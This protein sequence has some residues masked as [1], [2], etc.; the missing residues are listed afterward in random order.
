L[1]NIIKARKGKRILQEV[2][3]FYK[4]INMKK[5]LFA[6]TLLTTAT[7]SF[8]NPISIP[9][10]ISDTPVIIG[11]N[12]SS[13]NNNSSCGTIDLTNAT[14]DYILQP[15]ESAIIRVNNQQ[16][17]PLHIAVPE[18]PSP[19]QPVIYEITATIYQTPN[20]NI[21]IYL[22]P[23]N[24]SYPNQFQFLTYASG[25]D[26]YGD[27]WRSNSD[28]TDKF[29]FDTYLGNT[30]TTPYIGTFKAIYYGA[31]YPKHMVGNAFST[32]SLSLTSII[33]NDT[34]T[35]WTL[36]GTFGSWQIFS[37]QIIIK[38]IS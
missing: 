4:R 38:R 10:N 1:Y 28:T 22:A 14:S 13:N 29:Y 21:E 8:A 30:D 5:K 36:L 37:G 19:T 2:K 33:W 12:S 24:Y 23:N 32:L 18:P 3:E 26:T 17:V 6:L 9:N 27:I 7:S 11:S 31:S 15:C 35:Q 20:T 16:S 25:Y 34:T